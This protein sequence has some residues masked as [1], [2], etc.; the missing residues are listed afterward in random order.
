M[1]L[2]MFS[3]SSIFLASALLW[4]LVIVNAQGPS[5]KKAMVP[6]RL[7]QEHT[8]PEQRKPAPLEWKDTGDLRIEN[9]KFRIRSVQAQRLVALQ[10]YRPQSSQIR[11]ID[12]ELSA[13]RQQLAKLRPRGRDSWVD[14]LL[15]T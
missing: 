7:Q 14:L 1:R 4:S 8:S 13:L 11:S 5:T 2:V 3:F 15:R 12:R 9:L 10:E 6:K